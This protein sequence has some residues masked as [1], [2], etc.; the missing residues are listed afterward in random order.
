[1]Y[2]SWYCVE[3]HAVPPASSKVHGVFHP[4]QWLSHWYLINLHVSGQLVSYLYCLLEALMTC[5]MFCPWFQLPGSISLQSCH[6][7]CLSSIG[8]VVLAYSCMYCRPVGYYPLISSVT[9]I[10]ST[11][12]L[13][14]N[15]S[16]HEAPAAVGAFCF[17]AISRSQHF[18]I[19]SSTLV[20]LCMEAVNC[21]FPEGSYSNIGS[22]GFAP[23]SYHTLRPRAMSLTPPPGAY[24]SAEGWLLPVW[25][26]AA[27]LGPSVWPL[28]FACVVHPWHDAPLPQSSPG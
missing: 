6:V 9:Y 23:L 7:P 12:D 5:T 3:F 2:D 24:H 26:L 8:V 16:D 13:L 21:I 25:H 11:L 22:Q 19:H 1:M 4:F 17:R 10:Q 18:L 20:K 28:H 15:L 14:P 27:L